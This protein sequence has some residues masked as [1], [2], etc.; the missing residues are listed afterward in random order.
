[1]CATRKL[2]MLVDDDADFREAA[3]A[4]LE[5]EGY[6]VL[7]AEAGLAA[8]RLLESNAEQPDL[9]L[10]DLAQPVMDGRQF[11]R[12]HRNRPALAGI[13]VALISGE[14]DLGRQAAALAV[15]DYLMK[16]VSADDLLAL[17]ARLA[18]PPARS[19]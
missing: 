13:P 19:P 18:G 10:V 9:I 1:V 12:E 8:L 2:V 14:G 15:A 3:A 7:R 6:A 17:V 4:V 11:V 16:P 5:Q